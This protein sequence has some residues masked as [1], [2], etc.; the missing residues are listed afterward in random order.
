MLSKSEERIL[1]DLKGWEQQLV[2]HESTDFQQMFDKWVNRTFS[3]LPEKKRN[4]FFSK[5][6]GWLFHLHAF[7]QSSQSQLDARGRIL[8]AARVF[9][10]S[11]EH[12]EEMRELSIHQ[13]T[14]IAEQ[15]TARHRLYSFV[16]GG[17]TGI[18]GFLLLSADFP[19]LIALNVK[20]VQ[21]IATSFGH[22]VN[23]PYEM[24]LAL[25]VFHAAILPAHL[26]QYAWYNLLQELEQEEPA[27]FFYEGEEEV[28]NP[29]SVQVMLKQ[30]LKTFIIYSL[31]RKLFQGVPVLGIVVGSTANYRLTR[32]VTEFANRFYQMRYLRQKI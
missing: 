11:I 13:L 5:A 10:D 17:V 16:Q 30:I 14:Y 26:Q 21:L 4:E 8:G 23:K 18:G 1:H 2:Q 7:M 15:Q 3:K 19:V 9:D 32:S 28:L 12:I 22:D 25:K 24:M 20:A 31:R 6:D 27:P 29:A